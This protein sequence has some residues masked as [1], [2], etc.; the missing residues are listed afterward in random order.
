MA[1]RPDARAWAYLDKWGQQVGQLVG[2]LAIAR[3]AG[4]EA[5]GTATLALLYLLLVQGLL[6][7]GVSDAVVRQRHL[8]RR[9]LSTGFW[10]TAGIGLAGTGLTALVAPA[11]AG[12]AGLPALLPLLLL[13]G[14][15]LPAT[16]PGA[17]LDGLARRQ[18]RF[19]RLALRSLLVTPPAWGVALWLAWRGE[20]ALALVAAQ[21][22]LRWLDLAALALLFR[23][24]G[25]RLDRGEV[26]VLAR[27][28]ADGAGMKLTGFLHLQAERLLVGA[29]AG[30]AALGLYGLGRRLVDNAVFALGGVASGLVFRDLAHARPGG[31]TALLARDLRRLLLAATPLFLGLALFSEPLVRLAL[32]PDWLALAGFLPV[33]A[34]AGLVTSV[35]WLLIAALRALGGGGVAVRANAALTL[36]KLAAVA[37]ALP[38]GLAWVATASLGVALVGLVVWG[39]M[40]TRRMSIVGRISGQQPA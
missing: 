20:G 4:P 37:A 11:L 8:S 14:L 6:L 27:A 36:L 21:V 12:A 29:V 31:A 5:F 18:R 22:L 32:G 23:L 2:A 17:V 26:A 16:G 40:V 35:A 7:E 24:P 34:L 38:F 30:P 13:A 25:P 3:L 1:R 10:A 19:R 28:A 15:S 9:T 33:L 39:V